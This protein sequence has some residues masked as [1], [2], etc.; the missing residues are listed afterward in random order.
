L[1]HQA[2]DYIKKSEHSIATKSLNGLL[3][4]AV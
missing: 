2:L 3:S 4:D 1:K